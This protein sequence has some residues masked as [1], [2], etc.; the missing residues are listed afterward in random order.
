MRKKHSAIML[1]VRQSITMPGGLMKTTSALAL[2]LAGA[3]LQVPVAASAQES[4]PACVQPAARV[5][6]GKDG[7]PMRFVTAPGYTTSFSPA[8][9]LRIFKDGDLVD[10]APIRIAFDE[11]RNTFS[12]SAPSITGALGRGPMYLYTDGAPC[13]LPALPSTSP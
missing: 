10:M 1:I 8:R 4:P 12:I 7:A 2:A 6:F 11:K 5:E 13:P 3:S 9:E